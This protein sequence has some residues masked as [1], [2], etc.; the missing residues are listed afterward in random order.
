MINISNIVD[1]LR[2][3][4]E[5][6]AFYYDRTDDRIISVDAFFSTDAYEQNPELYIPLPVLYEDDVD[7]IID[8]FIQTVDLE[9]SVLI[10][11]S[12]AKD[13]NELL[14]KQIRIDPALERQ[15]LRFYTEA[16]S[17][18]A[19]HWCGEN[20][21]EYEQPAAE[22]VET[23]NTSDMPSDPSEDM[24]G[25]SVAEMP[26]SNVDDAV[27]NTPD[28]RKESDATTTIQDLKAA[29]ADMCQYRGWGGEKAIQDPQAHGYGH[30]GRAG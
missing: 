11:L 2:S 24:P 15:W 10:E 25:I 28:L 30:D 16:L 7:E 1:A 17:S 26:A 21:I 8:R 22:D 20:E 13:R 9:P 3:S 27:V 5:A 18:I 23:E 29:V 12:E 19:R 4:D 6:L 14:Q